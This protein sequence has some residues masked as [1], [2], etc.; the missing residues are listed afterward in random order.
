MLNNKNQAKHKV[1]ESFFKGNN[2]STINLLIHFAFFI[3]LMNYVTIFTKVQLVFQIDNSLDY[4]L[5]LLVYNLIFITFIILLGIF[6]KKKDYMFIKM[7]TLIGFINTQENNNDF[8]VR[9]QNLIRNFLYFFFLPFYIL[10]TILS[11]LLSTIDGNLGWIAIQFNETYG[12]IG[13]GSLLM[14][15]LIYL[16]IPLAMI[17]FFPIE[18]KSK[19]D[20]ELE[21]IRII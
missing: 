12:F 20:S 11:I 14:L 16:L 18:K 15:F 2:F 21:E 4:Y 1:R 13:Y 9:P 19:I 3:L 17:I 7:L 6:S 8:E 5:L 10:L